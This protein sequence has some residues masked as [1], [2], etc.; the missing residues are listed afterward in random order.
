MKA[1]DFEV[2][3]QWYDNHPLVNKAHNANRAEFGAIEA[4]AKE[5]LE[6]AK[7]SITTAQ[8]MGTERKD[9]VY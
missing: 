2:Y 5:F 6:I 9:Y 1:D 8:D 3:L 4:P 7:T